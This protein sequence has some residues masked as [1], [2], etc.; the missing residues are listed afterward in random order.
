MFKMLNLIAMILSSSFIFMTDKHN[1]HW[2]LFLQ[3]LDKSEKLL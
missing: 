1:T 2:E 3:T